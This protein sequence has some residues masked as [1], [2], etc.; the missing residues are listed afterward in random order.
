[1]S[2]AQKSRAIARLGRIEGQV[3]G[4]R[5]MVEED[6]YC[7]DVLTQTRAVVAAL[8]GVE[9]LVMETHLDTCVAAAMKSND[10]TAQ[11]EKVQEVM[12]VVTRFRRYG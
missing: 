3:R 7:V 9:D 6:R 4:I 5:K 2:D 12:D 8:R 1:M 11:R 10:P